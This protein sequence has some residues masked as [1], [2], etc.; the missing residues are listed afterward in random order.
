MIV[1]EPAF[2]VLHPKSKEDA[3][4]ALRRV[5]L[6]GR[7]C[8]KSEDRVTSDSYH[9]FIQMLIQRKHWSVIEHGYMTAHIVTNRG[10]THELVR[11]RLASFSQESTRYC[12]YAKGRFGGEIAV[13]CPPELSNAD[14]PLWRA[15]MQESEKVYL[16]LIERG[17]T[18]QIARGVLPNDLK[19]EIIVTANLREWHHIFAL[20]CGS[21]AHPHMRHVM[22]MGLSQAAELFAPVFDDLIELSL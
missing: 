15:S 4:D 19:A 5:E 6:A 22:R 8:Y 21:S 16:E 3:L 7:L 9:R 2:S 10:V 1:V 18:P 20:R 17:V 11:H 12:N 13:V 14:L